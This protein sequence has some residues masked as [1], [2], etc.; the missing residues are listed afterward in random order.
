ME[1]GATGLVPIASLPSP[2]TVAPNSAG[3]FWMH[4]ESAQALIGRRSGRAYRLA[5]TL[6]VRL[7]EA[8]PLTGGLLFAVDSDPSEAGRDPLGRGKRRP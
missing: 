5:N 3:E 2:S 7:I 6:A 8:S 1:S 4:D